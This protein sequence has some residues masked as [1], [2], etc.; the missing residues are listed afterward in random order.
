MVFTGSLGISYSK[1]SISIREEAGQGQNGGLCEEGAGLFGGSVELT[2][3][4]KNEGASCG[5][6]AVRSLFPP[7]H[8][9][10]N[11]KAPDQH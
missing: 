10:P 4:G 1:I 3:G 8:L 7:G 6:V 11:K 5:M 9:P 2:Q